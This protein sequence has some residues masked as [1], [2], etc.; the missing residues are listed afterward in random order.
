M[1][2][3]PTSWKMIVMEPFSRSKSAMVSGMRSPS[4]LTRRMMTVSYT[5]LGRTEDRPALETVEKLRFSTVSR[6]KLQFQTNIPLAARALWTHLPA[7]C[8]KTVIHA[9]GFYEYCSTPQY[10]I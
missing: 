4:S 8:I 10:S 1:V 5:H 9:P 7:V 3:A 6:L 2:V